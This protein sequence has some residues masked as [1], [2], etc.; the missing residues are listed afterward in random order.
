M[1]GSLE[2]KILLSS[3]DAVKLLRE[4]VRSLKE[5]LAA[6]VQTGETFERELRDREAELRS[7][8]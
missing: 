7:A 5:R 2:K 3:G 6:S 8:G 1:V 4:D